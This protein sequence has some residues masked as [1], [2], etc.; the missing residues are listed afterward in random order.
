MVYIHFP[1]NLTEEELMLQAKYQK[2]KKKVR[3][4]IFFFVWIPLLRLWLCILLSL[5]EK[6]HPSAQGASKRARKGADQATRR[7]ARRTWSGAQIIEIRC[8]N[9]DSKASH[10]TGPNIIQTTQGAGAQTGADIGRWRHTIS[11]ILI[12]TAERW[13]LGCWWRR[14]HSGH[15]AKS[16]A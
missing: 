4:H 13:I 5:L 10:Q 1:A 12:H 6:S 2:L 9:R 8:D 7:C 14:R 11:A 15:S 16:R 3:P